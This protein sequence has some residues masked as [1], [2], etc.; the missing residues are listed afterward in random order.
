MASPYART[1]LQILDDTLRLCNDFRASGSDGKKWS[2]E[3]AQ[4]ALKDTVLDMVRRTG[5]LKAVRILPLQED[6]AIYDLFGDCIRILRVGI[7]GLSGTVVLPRSMAEYDRSGRGMVE[8]GFP[9]EFFKD[10]I[11]FGKIGFYPTPSADGSSF[12]R[13]SDYGLLRR[14]VDEDGNVLPYDAN[15]ALR[16]ISGVPFT[17]TG[18]GQIIREII[19]PYGNI[20][21]TF[22]RAP[23]FPDNPNQY[24]DSEIP[25]YI[26]KDLKYGVADRLLTGSRLR[27][28]QV[29]KKKFGPKWYGVVKD[30][31]HIAE[32][33]GP[34]DDTGIPGGGVAGSMSGELFDYPDE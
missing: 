23:E 8:E 15:L 11:D 28:H 9:R 18:D 24:I 1:V 21:L 3:E 16:R 6:V 5:V 4:T 34:L 30:I 7:H 10:N 12:T 2:W 26:H 14:V 27:V 33:K 17:R 31:Q 19:S 29:K 32:H 25:E 22:V 20:M 13:D